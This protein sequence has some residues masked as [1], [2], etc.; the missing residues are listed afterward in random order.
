M[1]NS[2]LKKKKKARA[3][4][5]TGWR[6]PLAVLCAEPLRTPG[7]FD[8]ENVLPIFPWILPWKYLLAEL[9]LPAYP[10][11]C[12]KA[13]SESWSP[14]SLKSSPQLIIDGRPCVNPQLPQPLG[15]ITLRPVFYAGFH[16]FPRTELRLS[17]V[18][19]GLITL[20]LTAF[21]SL[22]VPSSSTAAS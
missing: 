19:I 16:G 1:F 14:I 2:K 4:D 11:L 10:S 15:G 20:L 18:V 21:F 3:S 5:R 17:T 6:R 22:S 13:F 12:L 7:H 8:L 9:Q